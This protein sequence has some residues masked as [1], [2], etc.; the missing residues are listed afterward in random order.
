[1]SV[2]SAGQLGS[3]QAC[4][5]L[6]GNSLGVG[7]PFGVAFY[8]VKECREGSDDSQG[9]RLRHDIAHLSVCAREGAGSDGGGMMKCTV[10]FIKELARRVS[11][12]GREIRDAAA[13]VQDHEDIDGA[14]QAPG[15]DQGE[16]RSAVRKRGKGHTVRHR[17][18]GTGISEA[19]KRAPI[20]SFAT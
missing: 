1:M 12:P 16:A 14:R 6:D 4:A 10:H 8:S 11:H 9:V 2:A 5:L 20:F 7:G 19:S 15:E 18:I 13:S 17:G 3:W